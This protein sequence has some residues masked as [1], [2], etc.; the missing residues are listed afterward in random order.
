MKKSVIYLFSVLF[1]AFVSGQITTQNTL[2]PS[3]IVQNVLLGSGVTVSNIQWNGNTAAALTVKTSLGE[4][5]GT[6]A[7]GIPNGV[8]LAT[9][10]IS[11]APGPNTNQGSSDNTGVINYTTDPD[12][13]GLQPVGT[14]IFDAGVLEFDFIPSGDSISFNYFFASEEYPEYAPPSSS[15]FNDAFGF[16]LTGPNPAGGNYTSQNIATIPGSTTPVSINSINPITNVPLYVDNTGG[17]DIEYDGRTTLLS[18]AAAVQC[19]EVYHIKLGISDAG[20]QALNSAVFLEANSF[21]S[22]A[23]QVSVVTQTGDTSLIE[24]CAN[25]EIFYI[26]PE[27]DTVD[28]LTVFYTI[29]GTAT[30]GVDYTAL[31]NSVT[32]LP[33]QDSVSIIFDPLSD[34]NTELPE[35]VIITVYTINPCGDTITS[36][37]TLWILEPSA[38]VTVNSASAPCPNNSGVW[39]VAIPTS[40]VQPYTFSW[41]NGST[42]DS[43]FVPTNSVGSINYTVTLT[44]FCG[45]TASATSNVTILSY[46]GASFTAHPTSGEGPLTVDFTNTSSSSAV[47]F[48]WDYGDGQNQ[49]TSTPINT[50]HVFTQTGGYLTTL[51][52]TSP[53]G[54]VHSANQL[55]TVYELPSVSAPNI[56]TPN[57][58]N[59]ND[60]FQFFN[61]KSIHSFSCTITNRWGIIMHTMDKITDSWDGTSNGKAVNEGVY[62][63]SYEGASITGQ[64]TSGHGFFHL[65][66]AK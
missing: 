19:G 66:R 18:V 1:P 2:T 58:D 23:I 4:F 24:G 62:F 61:V 20:D 15:S 12:L 65:V 36:T 28:S 52:V 47:L 49:T 7:I 57:S 6:P 13:I 40:G 30:N 54:C 45:E 51:T 60:L 17:P 34:N 42:N 56:F 16:F 55:I 43:L 11:E 64:E 63:Y 44:E 37:G 14:S 26:R 10:A 8:I 31:G 48:E 9:G 22:N 29:T 5:V 59:T 25:A 50:N 41:S 21:S 39:L 27:N 33:G 38:S 32:F 3:E 46:T 35:S 53:E